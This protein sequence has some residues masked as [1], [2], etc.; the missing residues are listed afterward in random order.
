MA[1]N[2]SRE[3]RNNGSDGRP[4]GPGP[5]PGGPMGAMMGA[6]VAKAND[7]KGTMAKLIQYLSKYR[8]ALVI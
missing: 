5:R 2:K 1:E 8:L 3:N 6:P 7:F 4:V